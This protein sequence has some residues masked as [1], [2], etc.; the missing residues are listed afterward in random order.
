MRKLGI[1][2]YGIKTGTYTSAK[3]RPY[4]FMDTGVFNAEEELVTKDDFKKLF[5]RGGD[6]VEA[7]SPKF[8]PKCGG[9]LRAGAAFCPKCGHNLGAAKSK[10]EPSTP[11]PLQNE[12]PATKKKSRKGCGCLIAILIAILLF[13]GLVGIVMYNEAQQIKKT[14]EE[15]ISY[16]GVNAQA[17]TVADD[18][19]FS[20]YEN[21]DFGFTADVPDSWVPEIK[22]GALLFLGPLSAEQ[23]RATINLQ[24][25]A[26]T[27]ETSLQ[28]QATDIVSQLQSSERF[29]M[30]GSAVELFHGATAA[31]LLMA[32]NVGEKK[33]RQLQLIIE[34]DNHYLFIAYTAPANMFFKFRYVLDKCVHSFKFTP[35]VQNKATEETRPADEPATKAM[36]TLE[37]L[38]RGLG[39]ALDQLFNNLNGKK[40]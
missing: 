9:G 6:T 21:T 12:Q 19:K 18:V 17:P 27:Q 7:D 24:A 15:V 5:G 32:Y 34:Q 22:N 36:G 31:Y 11:P 16:A 25:V 1:L 20:L 4:E 23:D 13:T 26:R 35:I 3:D 8:C 38:G 29:I 39:S 10:A 28:Q 14:L 33:F 40:N 2:R 37:D 30:E